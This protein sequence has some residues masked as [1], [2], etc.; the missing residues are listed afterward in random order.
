MFCRNAAEHLLLL[1]KYNYITSTYVIPVALLQ[2]CS[3]AATLLQI[4]S[5]VACPFVIP[6]ILLH[7]TSLT[8][9]PGYTVIKCV[10]VDDYTHLLNVFTFFNSHFQ[11]PCCLR[12]WNLTHLLVSTKLLT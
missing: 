9:P 5:N 11:L 10:P 2:N 3:V 7:T 4:C 12:K 6:F 1:K 8:T